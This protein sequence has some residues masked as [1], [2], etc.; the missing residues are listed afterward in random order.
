MKASIRHFIVTAI[1][2]LLANTNVFSQVVSVNGSISQDYSDLT[3]AFNA[4]NL[5][6]HGNGNISVLINQSH[7]LTSSAILNGGVFNSCVIKPT[8][9]VTVDGNFSGSLIVLD[10]A[11]NVTID[12]R[13]GLTN[14]I[15]LNLTQSGTCIEMKNGATDNTVKFVQCNSGTNDFSSI[16]MSQSISGTGG[17]NNNS[18]EDSNVGGIYSLGTGGASGYTNGGIKILR[19]NYT[20]ISLWQETRD[21]EIINNK[22]GGIDLRGVGVFNIL[23]NK[24]GG[25]RINP[26]NLTASGSNATEINIVNN[27]VSVV[28]NLNFC[29]SCLYDIYGIYIR[30]YST[31]P[32]ISANIIYNTVF[33]RG[34]APFGVDYISQGIAVELIPP[35]SFNLKNNIIVNG[36]GN[37]DNAYSYG[38]FINSTGLTANA[39]YNCY[40][41]IALSNNSYHARWNNVFTSDI[42]E[43][44][45]ASFP[46]EQHSIFKFPSFQDINAGDLHLTGASIGDND[47]KGI[48]IPG[49]TTD[50]DNEIR[51]SPYMGADEADFPLPVE[52]SSFTSSVNNNNVTLYWTTAAE[53]NNSGFE[54][55]RSNVKDQMSDEWKKISFAQGNGNSTTPQSYTF[56]DKNLSSGKYKYRLKQIDFNGNFEYHNLSN[57]VVIGVPEKFS[58]SKNY[59]NPFNPTTKISYE[60]PITNNVSLKVYDVLGNEV[61]SLVNQKQN[62]GRYEINFDG[63]NLSSGV[64]FYKIQAGDFTAVKKMML[65]K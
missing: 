2:F 51:I 44:R 41:N 42:N 3:S 29:V 56:E 28:A 53:T 7:T 5:G 63:S 52:L 40:I 15:K 20:S 64:Y 27:F 24:T 31:F 16:Y 37:S 60:L 45:A 18:I 22:G 47:L 19:N 13:V 14:D 33:V 34:S 58:L 49:I 54:I 59:P 12:G 23:G 57:E 10:G 32:N 46:N 11:D 30:T 6:T 48:P 4:V 35:G 1:I 43:Y 62:A 50:I 61:G 39:D 65:M 26:I 36:F 17:N 9:D 21:Y 8:S 25:I 55:E 38:S